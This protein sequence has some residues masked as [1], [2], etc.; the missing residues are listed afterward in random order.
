MIEI[1]TK[2]MK[3]NKKY[4]QIKK[5]E[6]LE[7]SILLKKGYS[8]KDISKELKRNISTISR[9]VRMNSVNGSYDPHKANHKSYCKRKYSKFQM[10]KIIKNKKLWDYIEEG[11]RK[12]W[13][14]ELISGRINK[15]RRDINDISYK[16]IY[17]F[18]KRR[19]LERFL[20]L[21][22]KKRKNNSKRK[23]KF[24]DRV[25]IN[26]R[27][28]NIDNR[29]DFGHWEG[30]FIVS[31]MRGSGVLLV[32]YERKSR[33]CLIKKLL[34]RD[35]KTVNNAIAKMLSPFRCLSLTLDN[36]VS[37]QKHKELS[38]MINAPIYFC[39]PYHSWEKGGVESVNGLIR[40]YIPKG[41][42]ISKILKKVIEKI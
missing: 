1:S 18:V 33:Y 36:D 13:S 25:F 28:E 15:Q 42:D 11:I 14:P 39:N 26:E 7:I 31:G 4:M 8:I 23:A 34:K 41:K 19:C 30:D 6:R 10:M 27:P 29:E 32:L 35:T 37:F 5:A 40:K 9:E 38:R 21:K 24:Q 17:K 2:N 12:G 22:G 3:N 16:S 20:K